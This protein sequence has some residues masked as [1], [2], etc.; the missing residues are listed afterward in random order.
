[1]TKQDCFSNSSPKYCADDY[2]KKEREDEENFNNLLKKRK[3][4]SDIGDF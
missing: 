2:A 3:K 1:M 4:G